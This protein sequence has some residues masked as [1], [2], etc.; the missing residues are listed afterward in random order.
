M[1]DKNID[2]SWKDNVEK[3][4]QNTEHDSGAAPEVEASFPLFISSLGMQALMALGEI[5]NP[6]TKKKETDLNQARYI[7][8][9]IEVLQQKTMSNTTQ[10]EKKMLEELLYQLRMV[11]VAKGKSGG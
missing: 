5:E 1:T 10:E 8:D 4:K 7:I 3:E 6:A 9:T 11:Y 2:E